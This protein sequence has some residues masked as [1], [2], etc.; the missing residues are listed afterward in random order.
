MKRSVTFS[1][2]TVLVVCST[3]HLTSETALSQDSP[4]PPVLQPP[5][6]Q[7]PLDGG[8]GILMAAGGAYAATRLKRR[9]SDTQDPN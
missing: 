1:L 3:L 5:P 8:L 7:T 6:S 4:P 9:S 2:L